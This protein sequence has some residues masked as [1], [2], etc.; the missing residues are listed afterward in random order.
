MFQRY[1][2][3]FKMNK[4]QKKRNCYTIALVVVILLVNACS[5]DGR[6]PSWEAD[7]LGISIQEVDIQR[8]EE[9]LFSLN[10]D[11][12]EKSLEP[13]YEQFSFFLEGTIGNPAAIENLYN[14]VTDPTVLGIYSDTSEKW[15]DTDEISEQLAQAF[16]FHQYHFPEIELPEVYTYVSGVDYLMPIIYTG[17]NLVI[18][19][20]NFLGS[21]YPLYDNVGIPRYIS[22]WMRA[23]RLIVE[24]M[25]A[26]ADAR[27]SELASMPETMLDHMIYHGKRQYFL[28]SMLP[29]THDTLKMAY[30]G[31]NMEWIKNFEGFAW[32][33][34]LDNNLLYTSDHKIINQFTGEA[35]FTSAFGRESAPRT[36]VW[37]GWQIV[38]EYMRR[39]PDIGLEELLSEE[40]SRKIL[41]GARYRPR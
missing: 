7:V 2:K 13:Y 21:D 15:E 37:L 32:T 29:R 33:Y 30:T 39:N 27:L 1:A 35:P 20:D 31:S 25:L 9:V 5:R 14:F 11:E 8:Y 6:K 40:D 3:I 16:R 10:T 34:K 36:G 23:E 4:R 38:R 22:R 26:F 24:V 19:L 41:A 28:D 18:G 17:E 12:L